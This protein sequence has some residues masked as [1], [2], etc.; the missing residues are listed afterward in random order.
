MRDAAEAK[1]ALQGMSDAVKAETAAEVTGSTQA[2]AAR[3]R[4]VQA[5]Q[6]Q[7]TALSQLAQSAKSTNTQLLY[8]GRN[9]MT[10]H[11]SDLSQEL[12]Y[13]TLLNRQ[14]WLGF[15]SV[16]QAMSYRQQMYNLALLENRA[17]FAGYQTADQYLGF[18][19]R[20]TMQTASLSAAIRDRS[21]AISAETQLLLAHANALQG[22]HATAGSLGEGLG[23][24]NAYSAALV[25]LPDTVVTK[26]VLDDGQAMSQLAAYRAALL[27]L[28]GSERVDIV[29]VASRLGGVPLTPQHA[30]VPVSVRPDID[31]AA[32]N[33]ALSQAVAGA[34]PEALRAPLAVTG[35][36]P[37]PL[38]GEAL[39]AASDG[40][41]ALAGSM[42]LLNDKTAVSAD[43]I[44]KFQDSLALAAVDARALEQGLGRL[45]A[46]EQLLSEA[47]AR[48]VPQRG[49]RGK[50]AAPVTPGQR[51]QNLADL[52]GLQDVAGAL[53]EG[54][55]S[56]APRGY[57][58][59]A[60]MQVVARPAEEE[61]L[62]SGLSKYMQGG[63]ATEKVAVQ[64]GTAAEQVLDK[65]AVE[66]E[67]LDDHPA[68]PEIEDGSLVQG[69]TEAQLLASELAH[70]N[71]HAQARLGVDFEEVEQARMA[72]EGLDEG[73]RDI[74]H[75]VD[76]IL[77]V[78]S[79]GAS[80]EV[81]DY[82]RDIQD[83]EREVGTRA[84]F[85]DTG[86]ESGLSRWMSALIEAVQRK[87]EFYASFGDDAAKAELASWVRELEEARAAENRVTAGMGGA[88]GGGGGGGP[89]PGDPGGDVPDP[90]ESRAWE[91][92]AQAMRDADQSAT[93]AGRALYDVKA[94]LGGLAD[95]AAKAAAAMKADSDAAVNMGWRIGLLRTQVQLWSGLLGDTHMI[96]QVALWH[97][98]LD[99][100][101][102]VLALWV[103]ALVTA[104]AGLIAFGAAGYQS[105]KEIFQQ[106]QSLSTVGNALNTTIP[107]L[108]SNFQKLEN[109]VRP[110]VYE[111][112]GDY[113]TAAGNKTGVLGQL[114]NQTGS[115]LDRFAAKVVV[116]LQG[117]GG[118][119]QNFLAVGARDLALIGQ[120]FDSLGVIVAKFIQAT[121]LTHVAEDLAVIGD[122]ILKIAADI[123]KVTPTP[124]LAAGLGL[125]AIVLWGGLAADVVGKV[126]IGLAGLLGKFPAL[127]AGA[128]A[129]ARALGATNTQ[130]VNITRSSAEVGAVS[131]ALGAKA[132]EEELAQLAVSIKATGQSVEDFVAGAGTTSAARLE[133][134]SE[135][136]DD[137][138]KKSV[139]LGIAAGAS[140]TQLAGMAEK[141]GGAA[142]GAEELGAGA[143]GA[144]EAVGGGGGLLAMLGGL[145][146]VLSNVYVDLGLLGAA[147]IA[148]GVYLGTRADQTKQ[149]T[150]AMGAAVQKAS[151]LT[152]VST[153]VSNLAEVTT[154]L[155]KAQQ[156]GVGNASE[157]AASQS[158][159]SGKLQ[160]ELTHVGDVSKAYGT[161]FVG[162]L[163][164]LNAAGVTTNQLF[165]NQA[166]VWATAEQQVKGLIAG[167]QAMGQQ[168][169]AI[170]SDLNALN[171]E[172]S[173]QVA[174]MGKLNTAYDTFTK[175]VAGGP[176]AVLTLAQ[177]IAGFNSD[178]AKAGAAMTGLSGPSITLQNDFQ[179]NYNNVEQLF[180]AFRNTQALA[181]GGNFTAFVKNAVATLIPMAGGSKE[182]A[183]QISALAQE[184]GGPATDNI[185]V[186]QQWVGNA[187]DPLQALYKASSDAAIG[188]SNL[189]QDAARLT[190]TLQSLLNPAMAAAIFN[191]HGGQAVFNTFADALAKSGPSSAATAAA[192]HN[193]AAELLAVSGSSA[194][195]KANFVGFGEAMGLS[196]KQANALWVQVTALPKSVKTTYEL[197]AVQALQKAD[198][199]KAELPGL[200]GK[201][202]LQVETEIKDLELKALQDKLKATKGDV[203]DLDNASLSKLRGQLAATASSTANLVKPGEVDTLL[204][205]FKDGTFYE[206]TFLAWIPQ[207]QR[208]LE[209][210]NHA[211]GQFFVHDLPEAAKV[212]VHAVESAWDGAVNWFTQSVPHGFG[213][214]WGPVARTFEAAWDGMFDWFTQSVPHAFGTAWNNTWR[215]VAA[216]VVRGFGD[217][218]SWVASNFDPWWATH[219]QALMATWDTVWGEISG[220]AVKAFDFIKDTG[221]GFWH[222]MQAAADNSFTRD[223]WKGLQEAGA[224]AW[225]WLK[226]SGSA[227]WGFLSSAGSSAWG[228]VWKG[229]RESGAQAWQ[230][231]KVSGSAVW[232]TIQFGAEVFFGFVEKAAK[233]A[234]DILS[235]AFKGAWATVVAIAKITWDTVVAIISVALDVVT[236]HW[237]Q[238]WIDIQSWGIQVFNALKAFFGTTFQAIAALAVQL[239][240]IWFGPAAAQFNA[241]VAQ[242]L[243]KFFTGTVPGWFNS[244]SRWWVNLWNANVKSF[245]TTVLAPLQKFFTGSIP[246]WWNSLATDAT[247]AWSAV[248]SGFSKTVLA[249]LQNFFTGDVPKWWDS[250]TAA[251][252]RAW[253]NTW[254]AFSRD[255]LT[256]IEN[257]FTSTLPN[258]MWNSLKG[259]IDHVIDGLNTVIG[260]IN[261]VTSIVGVHI[262]TISKLAGGGP[263]HAVSGSV[264]GTGDEDGTHIVAVGGEFMV[265]KPAR[266]ALQAAYGPDVMDQLNQADTWLGSG[267]RG[268]AASQRGTGH[269]RYASGG[270]IG[271][272][273]NWLGDAVTGVKG[274][275]SAAWDGIA[276]A[277]KD[278]ASFGEQAV[279]NAMWSAAGVPAE[280]AL[281]ALGTPGDMGAA[282]LQ[283]IHNGV[284]TWMTAQTAAATASVAKTA[285]ATAANA[286]GGSAG[287]V[288]A[289][290]KA[291]AAARGWTGALWDDLNAV[292]MDEAGWNL[293][294]QNPTSDAYG[295]AQFIDGPS[296]YAQYGGNAGTAAGQVTAFLNYVAQRYGTPAGALAHEEAYHWYAGGGPVMTAI[297]AT[298]PNADTREAMA[299]G[300][301]LLTAQNAAGSAPSY[302]EYGA[303]LLSLAKHKGLTQAQAQDPVTAARLVE[304][305]YAKGVLGSSASA[306]KNTPANAALNAAAMASTT[307]GT[308]W[309][310]P[311]TGR[312][313]D[314]WTAV[315]NMLAPAP[316][317]SL[318]AAPS[319]DVAAYQAEA[320]RLY[321]DW[322][323]ALQPW[324]SLNAWT[325]QPAGVSAADWKSWLATRAAIENRVSV[326]GSYIAPLFTDLK[327]N[328]Q[329]LTPAMWSTANSSVRRWQAAM[330]VAT[331]AQ[332]REPALYSPIQSNLAKFQ[333]DVVDA[334]NAWHGIWGT[335]L[336]PAPGSGGSGG[337]TGGAGTPGAPS[338]PGGTGGGTLIDLN[339]LIVGGPAAPA[340]GNMGFGLAGGGEVPGLAGVAG[341]FSGGMAAGGLVP[342]LFVPGMSATLSR[343]LSASASR[344]MPRTMA[345]GA[346]STRVGLHVDA[347][348]INNPRPAAT[349]DSITR[350][351]NR[352]AFLGGRG[353]ILWSL[354]R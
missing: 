289:L 218:T 72:A 230:W 268:N 39:S 246:S 121:A 83:I 293:N 221:T 128:E 182:A 354:P 322:E 35:S 157:L 281:E 317:Q 248:W 56:D 12:N 239:W 103:P 338:G 294:A 57:P 220:A 130:L 68:R 298:T 233:S 136:L 116:A 51:N 353:M 28:P 276:G 60:P 61:E 33:R 203:S 30:T 191:A 247:K 350:T 343:Q 304:P 46:A 117:G 302:G 336:T 238:A 108:T 96:G 228:Y 287:Q 93:D 86:A 84:D 55:I 45:A 111:L 172:N 249:P 310:T 36:G 149:F 19:Q 162:A 29:S 346:A 235:F 211:I 181:G 168:L 307:L 125:H 120:G 153:T 43:A 226:V 161:N 272:I 102:E 154:T 134:F 274:A 20:E 169:G 150:D 279:F 217:V 266:M 8:G 224:Q 184:A 347:L 296:E 85:E 222:V 325:R 185:K 10:Q 333:A 156:T 330:D 62:W 11:L 335:T 80:E 340:V 187:V 151:L 190:N 163:S 178:A 13:T 223:V 318:S 225:Q 65:I 232:S 275:A 205:S 271:N 180:D 260:W 32:V 277:A 165:S 219:G 73:L 97:I 183:A 16:Q 270:V 100:V 332:S 186:L 269:G 131:D 58:V 262:G 234:A 327:T 49:G 40:T 22:T 261:S 34:R 48:F 166:S 341:M 105:F 210:M 148:V 292:E 137:A 41:G 314:A 94:G 323:G 252:T 144:A 129:V 106:W 138:G 176:S 306:W 263:V 9:D 147:L 170:G 14:H 15:S 52:Y 331:L 345:D 288:Q 273:T 351:S 291:M 88:S 280:K 54:V 320:A 177:S 213:A 319:G 42:A 139:A 50:R 135:G 27:G 3:A 142:T 124:L 119:L 227:T 115:Y 300:S 167:Y 313:T 241:N 284:A 215:D 201:K 4:D 107:P 339:K 308:H 254:S 63:T 192:A 316:G 24:L 123:V 67:W 245:D 297:L 114:I 259:G 305:A 64:G 7:T 173:A 71:E 193:V 303:W 337:G 171:L 2:A 328:P 164:L 197:D 282:W 179:S 118:G 189:S 17:H 309:S 18:L 6:Q 122:F 311:A 212:S 53:R 216:P 195:A 158:D 255:V 352:L 155:N 132:S 295:I 231:L 229:L 38:S 342:S 66:M 243:G 70:L 81:R 78:D 188:A 21:A 204:K 126:V 37:G 315:Q 278:V 253:S 321:P 152:V 141:L 143:E 101:V 76:T 208:G 31:Y 236:G 59:P 194:S 23:A 290:A 25:G 206:L 258:A 1:A 127:N 237:H 140:D 329:E 264:P 267:S 104:G 244:V 240:H 207:V 112:L 286:V 196:A 200:T 5:I 145:A 90:D 251:A 326:A 95:P 74:P 334:Y 250:F 91:Q 209:I 146:P 109:A 113:L 214:V 257:F 82:S 98:L 299:L 175:T 256:P 89:P 77:V 47:G 285:G 26:A 283:D 199:L 75:E 242:P 344:E 99:S 44:A 159:L 324:K 133:R 79:S 174:S 349:E 202:K 92:I 160:E 110:Q 301:Y 198:K 87:Y 312:L 69:V 348:T 265:R